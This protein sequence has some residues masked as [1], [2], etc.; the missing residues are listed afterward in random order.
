M[1][2]FAEYSIRE[3]RATHYLLLLHKFF[4]LENMDSHYY[5][6]GLDEFIQQPAAVKQGPKRLELFIAGHS[7]FMEFDIS[8]VANEKA[9]IIFRT[10]EVITQTYRLLPNREPQIIHIPQLDILQLQN[11]WF[12]QN[13]TPQIPT[14]NEYCTRLITYLESIDIADVHANP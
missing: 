1:I 13:P 10:Y 8:L 9:K 11:G 14:N 3:G 6:G 12:L 4:T 2:S 5:L 7:F